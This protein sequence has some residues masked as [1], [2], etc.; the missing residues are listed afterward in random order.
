MSFVL[1]SREYMLLDCL[2]PRTKTP[3]A[4][5]QHLDSTI[6]YT[7]ISISHDIAIAKGAVVART[8]I[9]GELKYNPRP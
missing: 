3:V 8:C 2:Q 1:L 6:L 5:P 4:Y 7:V 9:L